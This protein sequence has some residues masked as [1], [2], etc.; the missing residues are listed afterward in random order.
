MDQHAVIKTSL[1]IGLP[2][3]ILASRIMSRWGRFK[4]QEM[5]TRF[6]HA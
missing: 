2:K 4:F 6:Q 1:K 3:V 5:P